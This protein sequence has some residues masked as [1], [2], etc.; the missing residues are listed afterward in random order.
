MY[1]LW[2]KKLKLNYD[3]EVLDI[4]QFG[5]SV[6]ENSN[7]NDIDIAVIF[8]NIPLDNQLKEAQKIKFQIE[9]KIDLAVH[10]KSF[11][12]HS[13]FD[14]GNFAKEA[15]LVYGKSL[16][17]QNNFAEKFNLSPKIRII[18][19]LKHLEKKEK[20]RFNY[21]L[22]G[23]G[24]KYGLLKKYGGA[25]IAPSVLELPPEFENIFIKKLKEYKVKF[26]ISKFLEVIE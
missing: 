20:I 25:I 3:A 4:V 1:K 2:L 14:K 19:E 9:K 12:M 23:R 24:N 21:L 10:V 16:I 6:F 17:S 26:V 11:D 18:Y 5:S 15:I 7:P 22:S 8:N 13:F